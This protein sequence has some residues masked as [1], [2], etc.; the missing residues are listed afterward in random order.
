MWGGSCPLRP[1]PF[2]GRNGPRVRG[3]IIMLITRGCLWDKRSLIS[4][5][6]TERGQFAGQE[7]LSEGQRLKD[8][9]LY[10]PPNRKLSGEKR[11]TGQV[12]EPAPSRMFRARAGLSG[13]PGKQ[14]L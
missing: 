8:P 9:A 3:L 4:G 1:G 14:V 2:R 6:Q 5:A 12:E 10:W 7:S 13:L 11:Q